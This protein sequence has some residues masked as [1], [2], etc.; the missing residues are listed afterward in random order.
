[1]NWMRLIAITLGAGV[2]SSFTD[3]IFAGDW[4]HRRFT[5]PEIWRQGV[6]HKAIALD[7]SAPISDLRSLCVCRRETGDSIYSGCTQ[8]CWCGVDDRSV[9]THPHQCRLYEAPQRVCGIL[10]NGL[11]Y[12]ARDCCRRGGMVPSLMSEILSRRGLVNSQCD[13]WTLAESW[14]SPFSNAEDS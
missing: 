14:S 3:W 10:R 1:M 7:E 11:A 2:V 12:Q 8:I 6:E 5:Y 4:I 9:T 13:N